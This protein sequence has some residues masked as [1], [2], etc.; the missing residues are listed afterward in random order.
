MK[1]IS[2]AFPLNRFRLTVCPSEFFSCSGGAGFGGTA[3]APAK[4]ALSAL[5][6]PLGTPVLEL[7]SL[8]PPQPATSRA[9]ASIA[10]TSSRRCRARPPAVLLGGVICH[11]SLE[12]CASLSDTGFRRPAFR[13]GRD[14]GE[15]FV[16]RTGPRP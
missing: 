7:E 11:E 4:E 16:P 12:M 14:A 2:A 8:E 10:S 6:W 15:C 13:R 5:D 3:L 1:V 9:E